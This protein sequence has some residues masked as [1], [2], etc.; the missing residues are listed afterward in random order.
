MGEL[1][2]YAMKA[3]ANQGHYQSENKLYQKDLQV[4]MGQIS[5]E[6]L[7]K[8]KAIVNPVNPLKRRPKDKD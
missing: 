6:N 5:N 4:I 8:I 3:K 1:P 2:T 7:K